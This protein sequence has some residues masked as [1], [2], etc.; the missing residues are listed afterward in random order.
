MVLEG[1]RS[2]AWLRA[3]PS[4]VIHL[5]LYKLY[6]NDFYLRIIQ[7]QP[8]FPRNFNLIPDARMVVYDHEKDIT[9]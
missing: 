5:Y 7:T 6:H 9:E 1:L 8:L 3:Q 2:A 4:P